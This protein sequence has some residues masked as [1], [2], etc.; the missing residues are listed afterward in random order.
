MV[1]TAHAQESGDTS[2]VLKETQQTILAN[3]DPACVTGGQ[4]R[5]C[6]SVTPGLLCR[7][8]GQPG[9]EQQA[10]RLHPGL[11]QLP[12]GQRRPPGGQGGGQVDTGG[13]G[14]VRPGA[15]AGDL[16]TSCW[17][18]RCGLRQ[19]GLRWGLRQG[20]ALP[21]LDPAERGGNTCYDTEPSL[22]P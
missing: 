18:L 20:V 21:R 8:G 19:A 17:Q 16:L 1:M 2:S 14:Q 6:S 7:G 15:G 22:E 4:E 11:R 10:V 13:G 5:C 3:T 12:G 9:A